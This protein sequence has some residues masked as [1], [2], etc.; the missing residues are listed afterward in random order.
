ML[1]VGFALANGEGAGTV[2]G[3]VADGAKDR[4]KAGTTGGAC[5]GGDEPR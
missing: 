2:D 5:V 1:S 3:V 4:V